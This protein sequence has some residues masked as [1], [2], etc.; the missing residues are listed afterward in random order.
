MTVAF[1]KYSELLDARIKYVS[2]GQPQIQQSDVRKPNNNETNSSLFR[3]A[4]QPQQQAFVPSASGAA[5]KSDQ[6]LIEF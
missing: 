5:V 1:K 6:P 2:S 4:A 3:T